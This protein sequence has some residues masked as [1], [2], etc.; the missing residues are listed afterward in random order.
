MEGTTATIAIPI[1]FEI[2]YGRRWA[3]TPTAAQPSYDP[4][5]GVED[6]QRGELFF[7][8]Y[9]TNGIEKA[10]LPVRY[11]TRV[12]RDPAASWFNQQHE[13]HF[14]PIAFV[15]I[16]H[17]L[18]ATAGAIENFEIEIERWRRNPA[19]S[20]H[21]DQ[22]T[23][24]PNW[25]GWGKTDGGPLT[26][27]IPIKVVGAPDGA[28]RYTPLEGWGFNNGQV[29]KGLVIPT[30]LDASV[31]Y[32]EFRIQVPNTAQPPYAWEM[33]LKYPK[34]RMQV[35]DVRLIRGNPAGGHVAWSADAPPTSNCTATTPAKGTLKL[36]VVDPQA[37][38]RGVAVVFA[39]INQDQSACRTRI[40]Y[41]NLEIVSGTPRAYDISG[42]LIS[43]TNLQIV[44]A[45]LD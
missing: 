16:P 12:A 41:A 33:D 19:N 37:Y 42:N 11:I 5:S 25:V 4:A 6:L 43:A 20:L 28:A 22:V 14:Q 8:L 29:N 18:V 35:I 13:N 23:P 34:E 3:S 7:V 24:V 45:D 31:P 39:F 10:K 15:D 40:E 44:Q 32:P 1:N 9:D 36:H 38:S 27:R 26:Q 21:F 2:G 17:D 30:M